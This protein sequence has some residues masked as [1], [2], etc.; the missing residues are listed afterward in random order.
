MGQRDRGTVGP[1]NRQPAS[2]TVISAVVQSVMQS[3]IQFCRSATRANSD[4]ASNFPPS[5]PLSHG[6]LTSVLQFVYLFVNW[7][8]LVTLEYAPYACVCVRGSVGFGSCPAHFSF[9]HTS[10]F[11]VGTWRHCHWRCAALR[12]AALHLLGLHFAV[13]LK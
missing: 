11:A 2:A 12:C 7:S 9:T 8:S 1:T 3:F 13:R 10:H 6:S 5:L 4:T